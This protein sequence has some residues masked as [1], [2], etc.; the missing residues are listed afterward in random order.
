M[1]DSFSV[2]VAEGGTTVVV[3]PP[4][5]S[6]SVVLTGAAVNVIAPPPPTPVAVAI[7]TGVI[8]PQGVPGPPGPPGSSSSLGGEVGQYLEWNAP[9]TGAVVITVSTSVVAVKYVTIN[10]LLQTSV[11]FSFAP[12]LLTYPSNLSVVAGDVLGAY[13]IF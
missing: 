4:P 6:V 13:L 3:S 1:S 10:G 7:E 12:P 2:A 8:G 9:S 11:S 5:A